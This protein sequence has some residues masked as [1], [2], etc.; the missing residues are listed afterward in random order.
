MSGRQKKYQ[1][2][3]MSCTGCSAILLATTFGPSAENPDSYT[4][5]GCAAEDSELSEGDE[6][7]VLMCGSPPEDLEGPASE[8]PWTVFVNTNWLKWCLDSK[9]QNFRS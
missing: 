7:G 5:V 8:T 3:S 1:I 9:E 2:D 6:L 4:N